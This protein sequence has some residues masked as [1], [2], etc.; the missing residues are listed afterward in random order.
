M[1]DVPYASQASHPCV[2]PIFLDV[3]VRNLARVSHNCEGHI[4]I[5][6]VTLNSENAVLHSS[7]AFSLPGMCPGIA[8]HHMLSATTALSSSPCKG[9]SASRATATALKH[10]LRGLLW[11]FCSAESHGWQITA[12]RL[13]VAAQASNRQLY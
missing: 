4:A 1:V 3:P 11:I 7:V 8:W 13:V 2:A 5:I 10:S 9:I 12:M 6:S